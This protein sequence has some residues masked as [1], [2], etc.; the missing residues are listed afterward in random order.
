MINIKT[1]TAIIGTGS[2][3]PEGIVP[4]SLIE[5]EIGL[6]HGAIERRT[7]IIERRWAAG[8]EATSDLATRAA[9]KVLKKVGIGSGE[10]DI[11][12]V[13]TT[14]PDMVFPSTACLVQRNIN[15]RHAAAFDISAS[16]S[17]FIYGLSI[18]DSYIGSGS[19]GRVLLISSETKSRFINRS[20]PS[21]YMIF[22][23]GAGAVVIGKGYSESGILSVQISSDG[24]RSDII[25][26]QGG[27]SRNPASYET[28]KNGF[29]YVKMKG[30]RLFRA[31]VR[32]LEEE[33][34]NI[35]GKNGIKL[36]E[37]DQFIIHQANLRILEA[38]AMRLN[39]PEKKM[40]ITLDQI[41]NTSSSSIP[42]ALDM[43]VKEGRLKK[44]D[45]I[46]LAAFGGGLTW[47][48]ALVRW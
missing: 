5:K 29:H 14:S 45:L 47:G 4:N 9:E 27:G 35:A 22:G 17:G 18:A 33:I 12:I 43:A 42:I 38:V 37:I 28:L 19:A 7:G 41:G 36:D 46:I 24:S 3:I 16:C 48:S 23:D 44:G 2:Y 11:I 13:S 32:R 6:V 34:S 20:D 15:A 1:R 10:I 8:H 39:I 26:L 30:G 31:A 25:Q 40:L 21:T